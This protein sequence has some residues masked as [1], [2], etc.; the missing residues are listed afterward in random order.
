MKSKK[1]LLIVTS[2][3]LVAGIATDFIPT[4]PQSPLPAPTEESDEE[5]HAGRNAFFNMI[6]TGSETDS[7]WQE[8]S[9]EVRRVRAEQRIR[10]LRNVPPGTLEQ[11][12]TISGQ[13]TERGAK[14]QSGRV[15]TTDV[16]ESKDLFVIGTDGGSVL[17]STLAGNSFEILN[18]KIKLYT[19]AVHIFEQGS[20]VRVVA[21]TSSGAYITDDRGVT[22]TK[23]YTGNPISVT[24]SRASNTLYFHDNNGKI[25]T[26]T[27]KGA[28]FTGSTATVPADNRKARIWTA[29]YAN[30]PLFIL[31]GK[32]VYSFTNGTVTT[33]GTVASTGSGDA[34]ISGN[35]AWNPKT[36]YTVFDETTMAAYRSTDEGATWARQGSSEAEGMFHGNMRSFYSVN[37]SVLYVGDVEVFRSNNR[38]VTWTKINTWGS[39]YGDPLNKIHADIPEIRS[40]KNKA[41]APLT[42]ISSDGGT[43]ISYDN[44]TYKNITM[45][46]IRN[47]QYYGTQTRWADPTILWAGAQDQGIQFC[48]GNQTSEI[49][50][51]KQVTSGDEGSFAT[52]DSGKSVW[53]TY[54]YGS[55]YYTPNSA[56][57]SFKSAGKPDETDSYMWMCPTLADPDNPMVCYV[58]GKFIHKVTY[59]GSTFTKAKQSTFDFGSTLSA[60]AISPVNRNH[61]YA[62]TTAKKLFRSTDN[63]VNWTQINGT[64][65]NNNYLV[66]QEIIPD[67]KTLGKLYLSGNGTPAVLVST[68]HGATFSP[69]GTNA[70][71][72][73]TVYNMVM[74]DDGKYIFAASSY[75]PFMYVFAE[76]KWYDLGKGAAPDQ[77]YYNVEWVPSIKTARFATYG[78]GIWDFTI[79]ES[80]EPF[81]TLSSPKTGASFELESNLAITWSTNS[82]SKVKID[83]MNGTTAVKSIATGKTGGSFT[84]AIPADV[85]PGTYTVRIAEEAGTLTAVSGSIS[86]AEKLTLLPQARV[87]VLSVSSEEKVSENGLAKNLLDGSVTTLW[88]TEYSTVVGKYPHELVFKAD[89]TVPFKGFKYTPRQTGENGNIKGYEIYVGSGGTWTKVA[90]G[91]WANDSEEKMVRFGNQV[92]GNEIKFVALSEANGA[93]YA[94]GAEVNFYYI[95]EQVVPLIYRSAISQPLAIVGTAGNAI[96]LAVPKAG[97]YQIELFGLNG[98]KL[99]RE[100]RFFAAGN[101]AVDFSSAVTGNQIVLL[102]MNGTGGSISQKLIMR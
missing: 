19:I 85:K 91:D 79:N 52:S 45:T 35:D 53:F 102:R 58:G 38:G 92:W 24:L 21:F 101:S 75:A 90:S 72:S 12:G 7:S 9:T 59:T 36:L 15:L 98:K 97:T 93:V 50:D 77:Q 51:F 10:S 39:Y 33:K 6:H 41:G 61:W 43:Y 84:W 42:L 82:S 44:V 56:V 26:S 17:L 29:R 27:D 16:L 86:I 31:S 37:D 69:L 76:N 78:R 1:L 3:A 83:L 22:W 34:S 73:T 95:H 80:T 18:D 11:F 96:H 47:S 20:D 28:T 8:T 89:T 48:G 63:G 94:S 54:V 5:D 23:T 64:I 14:N 87:S 40:Y 49:Y 2:I 62:A 74:S 66:G 30:S 100:N 46:G 60:I 71:G 67:P 13:W 88:H 57:G 32:T 25:Y 65:A 99:F 70:P 68:D 81:I 55:L 4:K